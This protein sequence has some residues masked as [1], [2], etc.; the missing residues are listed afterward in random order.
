MSKNLK[1]VE[2]DKVLGVVNQYIEAN[3]DFI[4]IPTLLEIER[5]MKMRIHNE[6]KDSDDNIL[7]TKND[8]KGKY[9]PGY[10]RYKGRKKGTGDMYPINLQFEGDL[11]KGYTVGTTNNKNVL[12]FQDD[13]SVTKAAKQELNYKTEI[14]RPS[15]DEL[16]DAK[17]VMRAQAESLLRK[18][19]A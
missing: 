15:V 3:S 8:R 19:F 14:F 13:L 6:G 17:E 5:S 7:G 4:E 16:E 18:I 9:S 10:E 11:I 2:L 12:K 1:I